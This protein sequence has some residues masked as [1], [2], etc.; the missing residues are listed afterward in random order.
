MHFSLVTSING[1]LFSESRSICL[2][3][4]G[5]SMEQDLNSKTASFIM[6][7]TAPKD[8]RVE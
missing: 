3:P 4:A 2:R 6:R 5:G 8:L 1:Q 7:I